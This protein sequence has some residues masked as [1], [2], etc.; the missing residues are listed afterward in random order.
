MAGSPLAARTIRR[1]I[2]TVVFASVLGT[3]EAVV[4]ALVQPDWTELPANKKQILAPLAGEWDAL[5]S[6][7]KKKW[8]DIADKYPAMA[9]EEQARIQDRMKAWVRLTPAERKAAREKYQ[10]VQKASTEEREALKKMWTEY[11]ALPEDQRQRF[12]QSAASKPAQGKPSPGSGV[13]GQTLVAPKP[14][15]AVVGGSGPQ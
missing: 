12:K 6:W 10:N 11:Q 8:L 1:I 13:S 5:E 7:R 2:A 4:P 15:S 14:A 9:T 3:A